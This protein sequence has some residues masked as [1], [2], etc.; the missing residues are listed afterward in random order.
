MGAQCLLC[1]HA[2]SDRGERAGRTLSLTTGTLCKRHQKHTKHN[3]HTRHRKNSVTW[4]IDE[5]HCL[6]PWCDVQEMCVQYWSKEGLKQ[7]GDLFV[8]LTQETNFTHYTMREL[9]LTNTKVELQETI[10]LNNT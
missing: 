6:F 8:E 10:Y 2:V 7:H 9:S 3:R 1:P 5:A 4:Y